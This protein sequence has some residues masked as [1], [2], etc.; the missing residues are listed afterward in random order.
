VVCLSG[1][2]LAIPLSTWREVG[3]FP[4]RFFLY[5]EDVDLS[6]RL[7]L[8]G[9]RL[10]LEGGARVDHD[11]EFEKGPGKWRR[12]ERNRWATILRCYPGPLLALLA[13]A[14][15]ATELA[16][17]AVSVREG[18]GGQKLAANAEALRWLPRLLRERRRLQRRRTVS[19][20]DFASWLTPDLD[21]PFIAGPARS[22]PVRLALRAY[23]R[24]VRALLGA[25]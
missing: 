7:R 17:L 11:Y 15:L 5:H 14:L 3:G 25:R 1:A 19:A 23:W 20:A 4:E 12:L 8:A 10:G 13:P 24:A 18:W 2:C 22:W 21:S 6:L 16:L 9:G